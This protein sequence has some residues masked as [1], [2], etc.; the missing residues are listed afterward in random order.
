MVFLCRMIRNESSSM[1]HLNDQ[2]TV[3]KCKPQPQVFIL[4]SMGCATLCHGPAAAV[5]LL[6]VGVAWHRADIGKQIGRRTYVA[7][8]LKPTAPNP[9][10]NHHRLHMQLAQVSRPVP[11]GY[12]ILKI[13]ISHS[14]FIFKNTAHSNI[15]KS[16]NSFPF[17]RWSPGQYLIITY[18]PF[19]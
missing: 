9:S 8:F 5:W 19:L 7:I 4:K 10:P 14:Y 12:L 11:I 3:L 17:W 2:P 6:C 15:N 16:S 1:L 18:L 13:S